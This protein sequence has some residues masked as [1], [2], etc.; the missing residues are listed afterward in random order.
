[1]TL[2]RFVAF[3]FVVFA[4]GACRAFLGLLRGCVV[5]WSVFGVR[6]FAQIGRFAFWLFLWYNKDSK[7][8]DGGAPPLLRGVISAGALGLI[9]YSARLPFF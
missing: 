8:A 7:G 1:V 6:H 2:L 3:V 4:F 9:K 5:A